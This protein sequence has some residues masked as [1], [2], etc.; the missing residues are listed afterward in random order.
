MNRN[1]SCRSH[2]GAVDV[3]RDSVEPAEHLRLMGA[4]LDRYVSDWRRSFERSSERIATLHA[5]SAACRFAVNL[6]TDVVAPGTRTVGIPGRGALA[7]SLVGLDLALQAARG[8]VQT[9]RESYMNIFVS[10]NL[11]PLTAWYQHGKNPVEM[12][13]NYARDVHV[14]ALT[15][16][17][18]DESSEQEQDQ[19]DRAKLQQRISDPPGDPLPRDLVA[20]CILEGSQLAEHFEDA[21]PQDQINLLGVVLRRLADRLNP[22]TSEDRVEAFIAGTEQLRILA[23]LDGI[24]LRT[25]ALAEIAKVDRRKLFNRGSTKGLLMELIDQDLV[26]H[27]TRLGYYR[28][29]APPPEHADVLREG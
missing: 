23:A 15:A 27:H 26:R 4:H 1:R 21:P 2:R 17:L 20:R 13:Y 16:M 18:P 14:R 7:F 9:C 29:D 22:E 10:E 8:R 3:T 12:A 6:H 28:P 11:P 24:A 19:L 5:A 25:D